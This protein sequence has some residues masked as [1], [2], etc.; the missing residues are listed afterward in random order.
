[1]KKVVSLLLSFVM[2]FT[3][4]MPALAA[5]NSTQVVYAD[6][7]SYFLV[8][9]NP[10]TISYYSKDGRLLDK[11]QL[12]PATNEIIT[13]I[14]D[15]D[16]GK[17]VE[18]STRDLDDIIDIT[19]P[20]TSNRN[21]LVE[22]SIPVSVSQSSPRYVYDEEPLLNNDGMS[23]SAIFP[24]W[25]EVGTY[26]NT[27]YPDYI[28][29]VVRKFSGDYYSEG[30]AHTLRITKGTTASAL[31]VAI[32]TLIF[33]KGNIGAAAAAG[34]VQFLGSMVKDSFDAT[35]TYHSFHYLYQVGINSDKTAQHKYCRSVDLWYCEAN[36]QGH[37][38]YRGATAGHFNGTNHSDQVLTA[39]AD[40]AMGRSP[41]GSFCDI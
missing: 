33:A 19:T 38:E 7:G 4:V 27:I 35:F 9:E 5:D 34:F 24:G 22:N 20:H 21:V 16:S 36:N 17:L 8:R 28:A 37:Y 14:F 3:L 18:K 15:S 25:Y 11:S 41:T 29:T 10:L 23:K 6:D 12:D 30:E 39:I 31:A 2:I 26:R 13:Q 40:Y 1:M 32:G